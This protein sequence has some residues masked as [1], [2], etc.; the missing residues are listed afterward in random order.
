MELPLGAKAGTQTHTAAVQRRTIRLLF[1][2]QVLGGI[3]VAIGIAVGALL[4]EDITGSAT[5]A[6]LGLSTSVIGSA[7]LAIPIVRVTNAHGRRHSL[8]FAYLVG[9][10]GAIGIVAARYLDSA[11]L[12]FVGMFCF[13]G[14][15]AA[16]LQA[17]Y[18]AVDLAE[19]ER[20][21]RQLSI[22][23]W[24]TTLGA[25]AGPSLSPLADDAMYAL[26]APRY[27]GPFLGTVIGFSI[28]ALLLW[29]LLRPDPLLLARAAR[30]DTPAARNISAAWR[31]IRANRSARL[32][33]AAV[34]LGH[35]VMV[36]VMVM[37]PLHIK[38]GMMD[39]E[40]VTTVVG[41]VL[42]LHIA[43][44]YALS[45]VAGL[46]TDRYG[47]RT[48]ILTGMLLL[49]AACAASGTA[50]HDHAQLAA[51][52]ALLGL[53]WSCT[54]VAGST[55]L[56]D[57]VDA[58]DR[59]SVQGLSDLVMGCAG[60]SAGAAAG[61]V[62]EVSGYPMLTLLAACTVVPVLFAMLRTRRHRIPYPS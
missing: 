1:S 61:V 18:A 46:A 39:P 29:T 5:L 25:V 52:L 4:L 22:I 43:G 55:M 16:N 54:M 34:A 59:P 6:G 2:T 62:M 53:G 15:T 44:M 47:K 60:A 8:T 57:A 42:S 7:L 23:V 30:T 50:G 26:G 12:A 58:D 11:P 56:T 33:I 51:G 31:I 21:G 3:G 17:R 32:G 9:V 40:N 48:V 28:A 36:A 19:P 14:G 20:L 38:H 27:T 13:G 35:L 37:A 10:L 49:L 41:I 45:P 24:A